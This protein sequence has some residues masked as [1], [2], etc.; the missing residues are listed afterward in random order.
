MYC[1]GCGNNVNENN[2]N[3]PVCGVNIQ[4]AL[5]EQ[6]K[7]AGKMKIIIAVLVTACI[8]LGAVA[9]IVIIPL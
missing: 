1:P 8:I 6:E 5:H 4:S 2:V 7:T 9:L 3:C